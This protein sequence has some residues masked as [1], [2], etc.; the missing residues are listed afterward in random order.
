LNQK[1]EKTVV[2]LQNQVVSMNSKVNKKITLKTYDVPTGKLKSVQVT[3]ISSDKQTSNKQNNSTTTTAKKTGQEKAA[4]SVT[5][6]VKDT[7]ASSSV[8]VSGEQRSGFGVGALVTGNGPGVAI[9]YA[10]LSVNDKLHLDLS[11]G[12]C[13]SSGK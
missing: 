9:N 8:T 3:V 2:A 7:E 1:L 11:A 4:V 6:A 5:K 10:V 12:A 13:Y